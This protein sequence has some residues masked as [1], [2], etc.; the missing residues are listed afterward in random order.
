MKFMK[1]EFKT[2]SFS[3]MAVAMGAFL[4]EACHYEE[5]IVPV[6]PKIAG[7]RPTSGAVGLFIVITGANFDPDKTKDVV[8]FGDKIVDVSSATATSLVVVVPAGAAS[9]KITVTVNGQ[10]VTSGS[11]FTVTTENPKFW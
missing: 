7:I 10:S 6:Q 3:L 5:E 1:V 11:D 8:N 9:G 2:I 4:F